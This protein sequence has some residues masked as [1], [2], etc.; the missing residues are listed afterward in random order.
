MSA[1][2]IHMNK[3]TLNFWKLLD[4]VLQRFTNGVRLTQAHILR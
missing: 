4:L 2:K 3:S 1:L